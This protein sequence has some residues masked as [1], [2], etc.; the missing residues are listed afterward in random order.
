[1]NEIEVLLFDLGGVL[2]E[3]SGVPTMLDWSGESSEE[4]IWERWLSSSTVRRFEA[5]GCTPTEFAQG[6]V[7]EFNLPVPADVFIEAFTYWPRQPYQGAV[8]MLS[9]LRGSFT[10]ACLSNTNEL[11]WNRFCEESELIQQ[12]HHSFPSH[13]TGMLKPDRIV[14]EHIAE[15]LSIEPSRILFFDDN[16]LNVDGA[17]AAGLRAVKAIAFDG[18]KTHLHA[19][20]IYR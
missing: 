13:L 10:L 8:E 18:V 17:A 20:G 11:H 19:Q 4:A 9:E 7:A 15:E 1:M 6:M 14:F 12:F 2:I 5:G 3:L 16:Q